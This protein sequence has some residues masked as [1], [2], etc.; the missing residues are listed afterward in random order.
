MPAL[1]TPDELEI[2]VAGAPLIEISRLK[3]DTSVSVS[4]PPRPPALRRLPVSGAGKPAA[5]G[6]STSPP[7]RQ[8]ARGGTGSVVTET[9]CECGRS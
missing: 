1:W 2:R 9:D 4:A 7:V 5:L 3:K 6:G 8:P